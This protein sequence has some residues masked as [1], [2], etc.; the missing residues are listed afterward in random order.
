MRRNG[1]VG[2]AGRDGFHAAHR[3]SPVSLDALLGARKTKEIH[4]LDAG[5]VES[6]RSELA[7]VM[8]LINV[9]DGS[10]G[11]PGSQR[12]PVSPIPLPP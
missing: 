7:A 11:L 10:L 5:Y 9:Q 8:I 1:T 12:W 3:W 6:R 2:L 4:H